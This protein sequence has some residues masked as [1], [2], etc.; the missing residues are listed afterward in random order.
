ML[1]GRAPRRAPGLYDPKALFSREAR[2]GLVEP[3]QTALP[4]VRGGRG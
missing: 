3:D 4:E 2:L 1:G